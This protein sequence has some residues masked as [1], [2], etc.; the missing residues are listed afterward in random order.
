ML[1]I[2]SNMSSLNMLGFTTEVLG[3]SKLALESGSVIS[4]DPIA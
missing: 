4:E 3:S 1:N 2:L